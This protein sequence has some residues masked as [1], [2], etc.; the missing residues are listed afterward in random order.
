MDGLQATLL[1]LINDIALL[2]LMVLGF[3]AVTAKFHDSDRAFERKFLIG[4]AFGTMAGLVMLQPVLLPHGAVADP[5]AG[6]A[7]LAGVFGG[8]VGAAAAAV[9]G[10]AARYF[11]VGG[12]VALGGVVSFALYGLA[13]ALAGFVITRRKIPLSTLTFAG[14]GVFGT[15]LVIPSFFVSVPPI[16]AL[17]IIKAAAPLLIGANVIA[18]VLVGLVL[19]QAIRLVGGRRTEERQRVELQKLALVAD[20][21]TN[22]VVI[23][24]RA[25]HID[26]VNG[27]FVRLTG[28]DLDEVRG[29]TPGEILQGPRTDL[30]AIAYLSKQVAA[31]EPANTEILNYS[32]TGQEYWLAIEI[33]PVIGPSGVTGF[34]AIE[35]DITERKKLELSLLRAETVARIGNWEYD[36]RTGQGTWS[37]G[38]L[39]IFNLD[40]DQAIPDFAHSGDL[41]HE[42]E[43]ARVGAQIR[44]MLKTGKPLLIRTRINPHLA[45]NA[46]QVWID[47]AAEVEIFQGRARR[48]FGIVQDVSLAAEREELL[49]TAREQAETASQA[50]SQFL[51]NM[52]HEIRTP[53]NGVM[54]MASLLRQ[55]A[56]SPEQRHFVKTIE[57][58]G[59]DLL[60]TINEIL[61]F[62]KIEAGHVEISPSGFRA[63][64]MLE[65]IKDLLSA[66][67][68]EKGLPLTITIA[69]E[70]PDDLFGDVTRIRQILIN[71]VSNAIKFTATG[72]VHIDV[73]SEVPAGTP[74]VEGPLQVCFDVVDT[75]IGI[76]PDVQKKLFS[77]FTQADSTIARRYGGTGLGLAISRQLS[78]LMG[79]T[80]TVESTPG[81]GSIFRV[82][83][84]LRAADAAEVVRDDENP[85][86]IEGRPLKILLAEDNEVNQMVVGAMLSSLGHAFETVENGAEA[87]RRL[88][89]ESFDL[90]LMDIHMP[91]IDGATAAQWIRSSESDQ[92]DIPIIALTAD[93]LD[94]HR[95]RYLA[96]G[97]SDYLTKPI[98]MRELAIAIAKAGGATAGGAK[99]GADGSPLAM[100]PGPDSEGSAS[101]S[102]TEPNGALADILA[103]V[104]ALRDSQD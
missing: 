48:V 33:Q 37:Q 2:A 45:A 59:N 61:D 9:I 38:M 18:T 69:P 66:Q 89:R 55:T 52:S 104:E 71:L 62:S 64:A 56:L 93:A 74:G 24:D 86:E 28:Y 43:R 32:K 103:E 63:R 65:Q 39:A 15:I 88:R 29:R 90:V 92:R 85:I 60:A 17:D 73:S 42:G 19:A 83:L 22:A 23:T 68:A 97:M 7:L 41:V 4:L 100:T 94:G 80:I 50:K 102:N 8:P 36:L 30:E 10:A 81:Q 49:H 14:V 53:M 79:G 67:A 91:E 5:R 44:R 35:S 78:G 96:A 72:S 57:Q 87:I 16:V 70:V 51:A 84:P 54:G 77:S 27:G 3:G 34:I 40:P 75:G 6:P 25:G 58:S 98:D 95:E 47:I 101:D 26:W 82:Q 11:V 13:G 31:G 99:E 46:C 21:T 12:P 1:P 76:E 20:R